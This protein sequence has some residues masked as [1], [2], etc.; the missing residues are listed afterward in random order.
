MKYVGLLTDEQKRA[1]YFVSQDEDFIYLWHR[2]N[3]NP[4]CIAVF[5]YET[6]TIREIRERADNGY[7]IPGGRQG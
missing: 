1:G 5:D 2:M 4:E 6:A 3:G 7:A